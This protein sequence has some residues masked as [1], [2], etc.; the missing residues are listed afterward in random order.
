MKIKLTFLFIIISFAPTFA[1]GQYSIILTIKNINNSNGNV[2][3]K[4]FNNKS[5][6]PDGKPFNITTEKASKN[7]ITIRLKNIP[8]GFYA[9]ALFHDEN[10]NC[11]LD[12]NFIGI[13]KE[14]YGFSNNAKAFMR[15]P[16][17]DESKFELKHDM[18]IDININY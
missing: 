12:E 13:P 1:F 14:G 11:I 8:S 9:I 10:S 18:K 6:F 3:I 5:E 16:T 7:Q 4:L 2:I 17:F 15:A